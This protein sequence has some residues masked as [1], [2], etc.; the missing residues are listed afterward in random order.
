MT[1]G[2][3]HHFSP[4]LKK[5]FFVNISAS[6]DSIL[7]NF[8]YFVALIQIYNLKKSLSKLDHW[9]PRYLQKTIFWALKKWV[10]SPKVWL[11]TCIREFRGPALLDY[12][13]FDPVFGKWLEM[14]KWF[15]WQM[16]NDMSFQ[17]SN[18]KWPWS[19]ECNFGQHYNF[20]LHYIHYFLIIVSWL[21]MW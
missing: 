5:S 14:T 9:V 3:K 19:F 7:M 10:N 4:K 12:M 11:M 2:Q 17:C 21:F 20:C 15:K 18:D 16:T 13:H 8:F 6:S 1:F